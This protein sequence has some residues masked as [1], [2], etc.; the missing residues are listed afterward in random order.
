M[1]L[2]QSLSGLKEELAKADQTHR[3]M[4]GKP[5]LKGR[6][7]ARK[8]LQVFHERG[9]NRKAFQERMR[10]E[11]QKNKMESRLTNNLFQ[12]KDELGQALQE[13][14]VEDIHQQLEN[15]GLDLKPLEERLEVTKAHQMG[16]EK[17]QA[18]TG[19]SSGLSG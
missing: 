7:S 14:S 8:V 16:L 2:L 19:G 12:R 4:A 17:N 11:A 9:E 18:D 13:I 10:Q 15:S 6:D 1:S 3:S 5:V